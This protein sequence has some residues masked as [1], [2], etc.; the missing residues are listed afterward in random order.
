[1]NNNLKSPRFKKVDYSGNSFEI[2][3]KKKFK[4]ISKISAEGI[5][6]AKSFAKKMTFHKQGEHREYRTGGSI[7]RSQN[8]IYRDTFQG[9]LAEIAF[10]EFLKSI[11][12]KSN[13]PDFRT[14]KKGKWDTFDFIV[15]EKKLN[16]KSTKH[17]GNLLLLETGDWN[18][19]AEYIP[20]IKTKNYI[21]DFFILIRV[22]STNMTFDIPG[23]IKRSELQEIIQNKQIV[24]KGSLLNK[25]MPLD[26]ENYYVQ[27]GDLV[28][29]NF[30]KETL[31]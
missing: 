2:N 25:K 3:H 12:I 20:N 22:H 7:Y 13:S 10:F 26:A 15:G 28:D 31:I 14:Y 16:V 29:I 23:F 4:P 30:L 6:N 17:F 8:E 5:Q 1:M 18:D 19:Q 9:K 27:S 11:N 24:K 21:Y